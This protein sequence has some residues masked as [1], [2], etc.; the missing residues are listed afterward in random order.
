[1]EDRYLEGVDSVDAKIQHL[2]MIQGIISRMAGNSF[3]LKGWA[4][5]LIAGIFALSSNDTD[6]GYFWVAYTPILIF[7]GLDSYYLC[8]ERRYRK[9]Y[10]L[11]RSKDN[12]HID[13]SMN[14]SADDTVDEKTTY[15]NCILSV[16]ELWFYFPLAL[17]SAI[18]IIVTHL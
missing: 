7:W 15:R 4:V 17:L 13:F 1:M 12:E 11:V 16:T 2:Q 5:T 14:I 6:Q 10:D 18:I 9:L 3:L 8:Q